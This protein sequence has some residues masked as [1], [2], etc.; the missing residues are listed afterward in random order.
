MFRVSLDWPDP[1]VRTD[2]R[3]RRVVQVPMVNLDPWD[4]LEK[5]YA[6]C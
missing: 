4:L 5:R 6:A 1:E 3:A 2:Q